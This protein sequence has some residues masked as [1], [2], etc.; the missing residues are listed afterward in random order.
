MYGDVL[1]PRNCTR[2]RWDPSVLSTPAAKPYLRVYTTPQDVCSNNNYVLSTTSYNPAWRYVITGNSLVPL[3]P[4]SPDYEYAS[5]WLELLRW[6]SQLYRNTWGNFTRYLNATR[7]NATAF[8]LTDFYTSMPR[9]I[10][11]IRMDSATSVW[12]KTTLIELQK[13]RVVGSSASFGV[14][15]L[16]AVPTAV[17]PAAA[18]A[19]AVAWAASRR[20]DDVATTAAVAGIALALFG[21]LMTLIYGTSSLTLVALGVI[22]AA[23]AAAW[24]R[25][26]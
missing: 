19:V 24:R 3:G 13:W 4:L 20:D 21:I 12:L 1:K 26:S 17:A 16:P 11:T 6:L 10:G 18:A 14:V 25:I 22:V 9:F 8:N 5:Q 2:L 23:A 7:G 15:S